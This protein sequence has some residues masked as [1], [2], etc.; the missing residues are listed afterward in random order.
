MPRWKRCRDAYEGEDAVKA[1]GE[2]Y[3]PKVDP[4][5]DAAGYAAYK[6]R[7]PYYESVSRTVDGFVGAISRKD[8]QVQLPGKVAALLADL[9]AD[10]VGLSEFKKKL[11]GE[12]ILLGRGGVLV[13]YDATKQR[14]YLTFYAAESI[15]NWSDNWI[16]LLEE[17][18]EPAADDE[19]SLTSVAQIRELVLE[20]GSYV[21]RLWR[22]EAGKASGD[23]GV[24]ETI[25]PVTFG[26]PMNRLPWFWLSPVGQSAAISKPPLLGLVNV[27]IHHYRM[28]ADLAHG[29]HFT[30]LPTL[31]I[32]GAADDDKVVVGAGAVIKLSDVNSKVGYAEFTGAGLG[33]LEKGIE[34]AEQQMAVLGAAVFAGG[35]KGVEAAETARIRTSSENSLLM[36][37][38]SSVEESLKGALQYA[39]DWVRESGDIMLHLNRDFIDEKIDPQTLVGMVQAYQAGAMSIETFL[40]NLDQANMLPPDTDLGTEAAKLSAAKAAANKVLVDAAK[41]P[42]AEPPA[43][44]PRDK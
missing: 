9:T 25:V 24:V 8:D 29:R 6:N 23:F 2:T 43:N 10:G 11:C 44:T 26:Q 33:S 22:R 38:V 18:F 37:V 32:T 42:V 17:F 34:D 13:E 3:L 31:Y 19:Y 39:A 14:P 35:K 16:V 7:A 5:Q 41:Q 27:S 28:A 15:L 4:T 1:A 36:G 20:G 12:T 21:V 30:A 40:F